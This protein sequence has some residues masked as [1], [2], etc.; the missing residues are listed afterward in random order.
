MN[1]AQQIQIHSNNSFKFFNIWTTFCVTVYDL[2]NVY[3]VYVSMDS[4][5]NSTSELME[6][7]Y[8]NDK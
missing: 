7:L 2:Y 4:R 6:S 3:L 1:Y 8:K 5:E